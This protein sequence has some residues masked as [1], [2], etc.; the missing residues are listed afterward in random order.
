MCGI[1]GIYNSGTSVELRRHRTERMAAAMLYRG[2]D[3][4]GTHTIDRTTF[5]HRR[6]AIIDLNSAANQPFV[7]ADN[8]CMITF[9]GEIYNYRELRKLPLLAD[10]DF[11]T[12]SDTEV[13]LA[14][15]LAG[16]AKA[17][18]LLDG[19][20][21]FAIYDRTTQKLLLM[22]DFLGKKP[23][24]YYQTAAGEVIFA[25]T[26]TALKADPAWQGELDLSAIK[27]FLAFS[28]IPGNGSVYCRVQQLPPAT[29]AEFTSGAAP[30]LHRYW[31]LDYA[32]KSHITFED[33]SY[34]LREK[35]T[36]AAAKRLIADVPC[37]IF[38]SGGVDSAV[39]AMLAAQNSSAELPLFTIGFSESNYDERPAAAVTAEF[40]RQ[41]T[42]CGLHHYTAQ[43]DCSS[44]E[45]LRDLANIYG[46]PFA[47][48]SM[49]PT[50]YLSKF[51]A[52]HVKCVLS[53]D[54]ADEVFGGYERYIAMRYCRKLE[55]IVPSGVL[56]ALSFA[57]GTLLP[58]VGKR[59]KISRLSR[60]LK[61][62]AVP[63]NERY[64]ELMT[65]GSEILRRSLYG[66]KL[67]GDFSESAGKYMLDVLKS[68]T[69]MEVDER[70]AECDVNTYLTDDILVKVDRAAMANSLEVRSPF[71]DHDVLEFA[72]A[73]PFEYKQEKRCRKKILKAAMQDLLAGEISTGR[74]RGFAVPLA[75][76]FR[77]GWKTQLETHLLE[78]CAVKQDYLK[79]TA[80][81]KLITEHCRYRRDHSELLGNLL[82]LELFLENEK[83]T[84]R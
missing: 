30:A 63:G 54:G 68:V 48:F 11:R 1:A 79:R 14:L 33:A 34:I 76:W 40:I 36:A 82:M 62:A 78:G 24:Y 41:R 7:S 56:R 6:L 52:E 15:Y 37:G 44:F 57:A 21:A 10:Y 67:E 19:M 84:S 47:D 46:E 42:S 12:D 43:V 51:A 16:G 77:N 75:Q 28:S 49:L 23:L 81:E 73:L 83:P 3:A 72:A 53:G 80:V 71:L 20:F 13:V 45:T 35:L 64:I 17:L 38:L 65:K 8:S 66:S 60:F 50:Y 59:S 18:D 70:Y 69:T 2:P 61:L 22:R 26:L 55:Q 74:K 25:S 27:D 58:D 39:T 4:G 9:N 31:Q 29:R 32:H 5:V